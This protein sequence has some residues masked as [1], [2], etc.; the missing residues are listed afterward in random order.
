MSNPIPTYD[1]TAISE[2]ARVYTG[3]TYPTKPNAAPRA[4][5]PAYYIGDMVAWEP[6]HDEGAK[7]LLNGAKDDGGKSAND[8][9]NFAL[10]DI[11]NHPNVG[12]FVATKLIKQLVT[13]NP[14]PSYVARVENFQSEPSPTM[15][16]PSCPR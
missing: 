1:Q 3:W 11:F 8:D 16:G 5:N 4:F 14:S 9:L 7:I 2:F 6:N 12:P 10:D 13:S 15:R